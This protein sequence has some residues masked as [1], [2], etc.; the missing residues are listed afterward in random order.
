MTER[1]EDIR[2]LRDLA[3]QVADIAA[4]PVQ[5]ERRKL[6]SAHFSLKKTRPLVL[7]NYGMHNVWCREVFGDHAMQCQ[8]PFFRGHER[9]LRMQIF[10]DTV[11]D[12]HIVEPWMIEGG[13]RKVVGGHDG[14]PWG[15]SPQRDRPEEEGGAYRWE[16]F[17]KTWAD[18]SKLVP[19]VHEIDEAAS[20]RLV[21]RLGDAVGDIL[22]VDVWRAPVLMDFA[23]DIST[24]A[25]FLRG[26]EQLMIDMYEAPQELHRLHAFLRDGIL[27]NQQQAE[28]AGDYSLTTQTNQAMPYAEELEPPRANSGPRVRSE[29]WG[30][31]AAQEYT[32]I[33]PAFHDEFLFQYQMPILKNFALVHY[34]CCED[35]TEKITM[36]RQLENLRSI[37]VTPVADVGKCAERIGADYAISWRP[38]PTDMVSANWDPDRIRKIIRHG[39]DACA[40][41]YLHILLKDVE[42]VCG[43]PDRLARWTRIVREVTE[44]QRS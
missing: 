44:T 2:I 13:V 4:K 5:E 24:T 35:L 40:D 36:L 34:G 39:A 9:Y 31:G 11:G 18:M 22:E 41:G 3:K 7:A 21:Q 28:D 10:H 17:L 6:W 8:D 32:L 38:N 27:A 15:V 12:D 33:S 26:L 14:Q 25:G 29:L 30:F 16:P 43:E 37:A 20:T 23:A 42:T 1:R 19:P